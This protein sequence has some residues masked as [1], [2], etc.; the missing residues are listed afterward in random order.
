MRTR[1]WVGQLGC[2]KYAILVVISGLLEMRTSLSGVIFRIALVAR[3]P[4]QGKKQ[5]ML[6]K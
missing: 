5:C 4:A 6:D 1:P 2:G 3:L